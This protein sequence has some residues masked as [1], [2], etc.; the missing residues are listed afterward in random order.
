MVEILGQT[1]GFWSAIVAGIFI[2]L[3]IPSC[4]KH[5]A[6]RLKPLSK[7]LVRFHDKTLILATLFAIIHIILS[8]TGLVFNIWIKK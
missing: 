4:N 8:I 3:H 6:Y 7:Y 2:L 5:W 1:I